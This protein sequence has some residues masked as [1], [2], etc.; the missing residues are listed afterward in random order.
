[1]V[2]K[3]KKLLFGLA[4]MLSAVLL[5]TFIL[6]SI[7]TMEWEFP[8]FGGTAYIYKGDSIDFEVSVNSFDPGAS[9]TIDLFDADNN[10]ITNL[11][12]GSTDGNGL[13]SERITI[14]PTDY[15]NLGGTYYVRT[16]ST[17]GSG[18]SLSED[19][20]T[21]T[22]VVLNSGPF[23]FG[24]PD[25]TMTSGETLVAFDLDDY[26]FDD[27]PLSDLT[28]VAFGNSNVAVSIDPITHVVTLTA[29]VGF[30]GDEFITFE[31]T[32]LEGE[33]DWD[34]IR[35]TVNAP[36]TGSGG[37][38]T[39]KEATLEGFSIEDAED[40]FILIR[41]KGPRVEDLRITLYIETGDEILVRNLKMD[42]S[43]NMVRYEYLDFDE[44]EIEPGTYL[45]KV[46][47]ESS[48]TDSE[49]EGYLLLEL[50]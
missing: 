14:T 7:N 47:A 40:N 13:Y 25:V 29:A 18:T 50:E 26:V 17:E 19:V 10:L 1:M 9:Y 45:T 36:T 31:A 37:S 38:T 16:Y 35:V 22:L 41:N 32:D 8:F 20:T 30:T 43:K 46:K 42:L 5:S 44:G 23:V 49:E 24:L 28:W 21:L 12:S 4:L 39:K 3:N 11:R 6:A 33:F 2:K 48:D 27:G 15:S 34:T